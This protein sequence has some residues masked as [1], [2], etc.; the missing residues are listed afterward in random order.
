ME[1]DPERYY[2]PCRLFQNL[3][4]SEII[5]THLRDWALLTRARLRRVCFWFSQKL[6]PA[7]PPYDG[8]AYSAEMLA[9]AEH[10]L[11]PPVRL[12]FTPRA[13]PWYHTRCPTCGSFREDTDGAAVWCYNGHK[14][15]QQYIL[16]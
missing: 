6:A 16:T 3:W 14:W 15:R 12:H 5:A 2:P 4:L 9:W 1:I 11:T 10:G 13:Y 8:N 7:R